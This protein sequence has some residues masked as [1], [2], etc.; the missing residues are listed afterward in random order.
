M[1]YIANYHQSTDHIVGSRLA[2]NVSWWA[3]IVSRWANIVSCSANIVSQLSSFLHVT[4]LDSCQSINRHLTER[5]K[6][7]DLQVQQCK[8]DN[9]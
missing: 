8:R 5:S 6:R 4:F 9:I 7:T 2:N 1:A 3:N